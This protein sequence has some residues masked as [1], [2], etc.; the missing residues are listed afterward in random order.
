MCFC[1]ATYIQRCFLSLDPYAQSPLEYFCGVS[2]EHRGELLV[3]E[4]AKLVVDHPCALPTTKEVCYADAICASCFAHCT[5]ASG[6]ADSRIRSSRN[7][8]QPVR[9]AGTSAHSE[10]QLYIP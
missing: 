3:K 1:F 9:Y 4:L 10:D 7:S 6:K 2:C 5:L 8:W